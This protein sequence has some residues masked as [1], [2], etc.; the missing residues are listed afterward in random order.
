MGRLMAGLLA[1]VLSACMARHE[2][3]MKESYHA[4]EGRGVGASGYGMGGGGLSRAKGMASRGRVS[5]APAAMAGAVAPDDAGIEFE[6]EAVEGN[7]DGGSAEPRMVHYNGHLRLEVSR[8]DE[9]I[10]EVVAQAKKVGGYVERQSRT[11]VSLRVPVKVFQET[12]DWVAAKGDVLTRSMTARD[13]TDA[14]FALSLRLSTATK[15]RDRLQELLARA[16]D[17]KT[18]IAILKQIQRL[19][20]QIDTMER[21]RKTLSGLANMSRLTVEAESR[22]AMVG[23]KDVVPVDGFQWIARLSPFSRAVAQVNEAL[24]L[25]TPEGLVALTQKD[26]FQAESADGVIFWSAQLDNQPEGSAQFWQSA[27]HSRIADEF[28]T[29]QLGRVGDYLTIRLV[30]PSEEPYVYVIA[31]KVVGD[32]LHLVETYYPSEAAEDRHR[33]QVEAVLGGGAS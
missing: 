9:T 27:I 18:K 25:S 7:D 28:A 14:H 17:E 19:T 24:R 10:A 16:D 6:E 1:L 3:P 15:T 12:F 5:A 8:P 4:H 13:V 22:A 20:E 33:P 11:S 31:L 23:A 29:A 30:A 21:Q 26:R 32:E 2:A